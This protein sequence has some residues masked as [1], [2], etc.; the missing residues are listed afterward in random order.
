MEAIAI[1]DQAYENRSL[2]KVKKILPVLQR[3][4]PTDSICMIEIAP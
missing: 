2:I 3:D 4:L 1:G